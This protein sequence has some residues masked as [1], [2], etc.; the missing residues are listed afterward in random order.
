MHDV[1]E[2]ETMDDD[3]EYTMKEKEICKRCMKQ[4]LR[5]YGG[6]PHNTKGKEQKR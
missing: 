1:I 4:W 3:N 2:I 6:N 5:T